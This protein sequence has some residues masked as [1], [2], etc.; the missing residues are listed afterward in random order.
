MRIGC[1]MVSRG[2][3][4]LIVASKGASVGLMSSALFGPVIVVVVATTIISPILL[5]LAYRNDKKQDVIVD[6]N[7]KKELSA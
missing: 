1:G 3:V 4:A 2:E 5:K 7:E 6:N